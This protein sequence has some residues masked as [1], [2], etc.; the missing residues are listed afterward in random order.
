VSERAIEIKVGILVTVCVALLVVFVV[1]LGDF[2]MSGGGRIFLDVDTSAALKVGA[3]VKVAGVPSGKVTAVDYRGGAVDPAVG[4]PVQVRVTL[5]VADEKLATLRRD[6]RF[7]ITTQGVLGEKYVEIEPRGVDAP[8]L[9][10]DAVVEGEQP[11]RLEIMAMNANTVLSS[12]SELLRKNEGNLDDIISD[13]AATMRTVRKVAERADVL[14]A[15]NSPKVGQVIDDLLEVEAEVK[16]LAVAANAVIG[17]GSEA[18]TAILNIS[19]LSG[20]VREAIGPVVTDVRRTLAKYG[21]LAD[22]GRDFVGEVRE[23]AARSLGNVDA[24]IADVKAVT[25]KIR[26]GQG[27]IG[28]LLA[29]KEMYDDIREMMKDLKR[30]PWKFIWKE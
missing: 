4:R 18:R 27:T 11:L 7:Y 24:V 26:D 22:S 12:L 30:H 3:P 13:A 6:A 10:P 29:D 8:L 5:T 9:G 17:D 2:S 15:D 28:A 14:L 16:K 19:A 21:D 20:D 23:V 1:L 25:S